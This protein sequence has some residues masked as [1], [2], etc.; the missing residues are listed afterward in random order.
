MVADPAGASSFDP[1]GP[2]DGIWWTPV[3]GGQVT[4]R[5]SRVPLPWRHQ[6][7]GVDRTP[8]V[9]CAEEEVAAGRPRGPHP[10]PDGVRAR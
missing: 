3:A 1:A 2:V 5:P 10:V 8:P 7:A 4:V 9:V 6:T